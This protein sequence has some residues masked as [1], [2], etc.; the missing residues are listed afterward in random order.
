M[1]VKSKHAAKMQKNDREGNFFLDYE[2][3]FFTFEFR[4]CRFWA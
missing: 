2:P 3:N 4:I 1:V